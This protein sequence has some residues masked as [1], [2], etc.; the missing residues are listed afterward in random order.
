MKAKNYAPL[1]EQKLGVNAKSKSMAA[2]AGSA[3]ADHLDS[4]DNNVKTEEVAAKLGFMANSEKFGSPVTKREQKMGASESKI[5]S[6]VG[7]ETEGKRNTSMHNIDL[8]AQ[9]G[10]FADQT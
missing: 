1:A 3:F 9:S 2:A 10:V 4:E 7:N 8:R 5:N 6:N